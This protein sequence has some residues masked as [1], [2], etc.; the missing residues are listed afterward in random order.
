[1]PYTSRP[2]FSDLLN[3][4]AVRN[5]RVRGCPRTDIIS[6]DYT[7]SIALDTLRIN[8]Y[9]LSSLIC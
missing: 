8:Y 6:L 4:G 2:V 3:V 5:P 1:M 7:H 9:G